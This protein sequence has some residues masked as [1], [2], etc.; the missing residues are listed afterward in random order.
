MKELP[1]TLLL[2]PPGFRTLATV[3]WNAAEGAYWTQAAVASLLL[4]AVSGMLTWMLVIRRADA[5]E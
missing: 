3:I 2:S 1:A 4:V 5:V